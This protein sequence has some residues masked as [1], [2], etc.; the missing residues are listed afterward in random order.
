MTNKEQ[1]LNKK[2]T[3]AKVPY[4]SCA[5]LFVFEIEGTCALVIRTGVKI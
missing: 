3:V 4:V 5:I 1:L 2:Q